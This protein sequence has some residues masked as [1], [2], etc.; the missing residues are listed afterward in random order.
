MGLQVGL[1]SRCDDRGLG[2]SVPGS[3]SVEPLQQVRVHQDRRSLLHMLSYIP[4]LPVGRARLPFRHPATLR[5][6]TVNR[7]E[8]NL[9]IPGPTSLPDAVR[10]AG[11]R[12][13]VNHRGP[14][15]A[16]LQNRVI[17]RLKT[18]YKTENDVL[19]VTAAGTGGPR[20]GDR[21]LP[22]PRRQGPGRQHRR[23]RRSLREDR[24]GLRRGRHEAVVRL[25][26]GGRSGEGS[27]GSRAPAARGRPSFSPRTR[28]RRP[29]RT[30]SPSWRRPSR[31]SPRTR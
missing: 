8:P 4:Q 29:S 23:L 7:F 6:G 2:R 26:Q 15:F 28:P 12:Q 22:L 16:A 14:E 27:R 30:R 21:Q 17:D 1:Q 19:I 24:L 5:G 25:G 10:E 11:A 9:R 13:M 18:F 3:E 20:V 31:R